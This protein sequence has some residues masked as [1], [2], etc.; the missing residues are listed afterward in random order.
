MECDTS[1]SRLL[2]G[3]QLRQVRVQGGQA[4]GGRPV[5]VPPAA[6]RQAEPLHL[7]LPHLPAIPPIH[8]SNLCCHVVL[9]RYVL[10]ARLNV[11][12]L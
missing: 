1:S 12:H 8:R 7:Q 5:P 10:P 11:L 9:D 6:A 2:L 4:V 3:L